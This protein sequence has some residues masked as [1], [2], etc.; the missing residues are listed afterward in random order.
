MTANTPARPRILVVRNDRLGDFMLAYPALGLLKKNMPH[1]EVH[2]LIP[3]YT[4]EMAEACP[5]IDHTVIDPGTDADLGALWGL[6]RNIRRLGIDTAITLFSTT[7]VGL[8]LYAAGVPY[9]LAPASKLAQVFYNHRLVQRRSRSEKP[10]YVYNVDLVRCFLE[11]RGV[12]LET[13]PAPP[14]LQF[15]TARVAR[16]KSS[17]C[18]DRGI[19]CLKKL[20][21]LHPG[22]GGSASNLSVEQFARLG[23]C[24]ES[25]DGH[26]I[27][28]TAGPG[29]IETAQALSAGLTGTPHTVYQSNQ[30][31]RLFAE[32]IQFADLF[33]SGSTGPLHIAGAL[34]RP[35][36]A[37]YTRR[38]SA[39]ALRWQT[40]NTPERRLAFSAENPADTE[41]MQS[42]DVDTAART[43][44]ERYLLNEN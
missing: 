28:V 1:A 29:E 20:V 37:F 26:I 18:R 14:Y 35:T 32:H 19:D 44:S 8:A 3:E 21:F 38:R 9:R 33:I 42:I 43:I 6:V 13:E 39:T 10:E 41:D 40:L 36:A 34:D 5:W 12:A 11:D 2:A 22:G 27:V 17:F 4:R 31:L 7:R 23:A 16:L 15:D 30:G 24:L 25:H